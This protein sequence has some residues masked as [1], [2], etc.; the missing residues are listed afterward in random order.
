MELARQFHCDPVTQ[1]ATD[2]PIFPYLLP[3][4]PRQPRRPQRLQQR[5]RPPLGSHYNYSDCEQYDRCDHYKHRHTRRFNHLCITGID[6]HDKHIAVSRKNDWKSSADEPHQCQHL[7][8]IE[9]RNTV[10]DHC[11]A[12]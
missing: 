2:Y 5:L 12:G 9:H 6:D 1:T 11:N 3:K 10:H 8:S 7:H 4:L